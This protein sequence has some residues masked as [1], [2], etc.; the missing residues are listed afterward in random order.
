MKSRNEL[1]Q[2]FREIDEDD[3]GEL[4]IYEIIE[5]ASKIGITTPAEEI[6]DMFRSIDTDGNGM[7]SFDEFVSWYRLGQDSQLKFFLKD[8]MLLEKKFKKL[9]E[10]YAKKTNFNAGDK[11]E[12]FSFEIGHFSNRPTR[13]FF[14]VVKNDI[15]EF[16]S[17]FEKLRITVKNLTSEQTYK[18]DEDFINNPIIIN[19]FYNEDD[20]TIRVWDEMH[21]KKKVLITS[22]E[23]PDF[24]DTKSEIFDLSLLNT[25]YKGNITVNFYKKD[26]CEKT[27]F[28]SYFSHSANTNSIDLLKKA[29]PGYFE[30]LE[31]PESLGHIFYLVTNS[32]EPESLSNDFNNF[33]TNLKDLLCEQYPEFTSFITLQTWQIGFVDDKVVVGFDLIK[34]PILTSF[35]EIIMNSVDIVRDLNLES[36]AELKFGVDLND[37]RKY[38]SGKEQLLVKLFDTWR[39]SGFLKG[40]LTAL[41]GNISV[42]DLFSIEEKTQIGKGGLVGLLLS[43][44]FRTFHIKYDLNNIDS[45]ELLSKTIQSLNMKIDDVNLNYRELLFM[46]YNILNLKRIKNSAPFINDF[47]NQL[48][49]KSLAQG[50]LGILLSN[51]NLELDFSTSGLAEF[52]NK[53]I[54]MDD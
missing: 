1:L 39:C 35:I 49:D 27:V 28:K 45:F 53:L 9:S 48:H 15:D 10:K 38:D 18:L 33:F 54:S 30:S 17:W 29:I 41:R 14:E 32:K 46:C 31:D 37:L 23:V 51:F 19:G 4:D 21:G 2:Q 42:F 44:L 50:S 16:A 20:I 52:Y 3:S 25:R 43:Q 40:D 7:I 8:Q 34:Q 24:P 12:T 11:L 22:E 36:K 5:L 26:L 13:F 47:L 6:G